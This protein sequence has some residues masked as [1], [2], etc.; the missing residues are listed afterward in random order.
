MDLRKLPSSIEVLSPAGTRSFLTYQPTLVAALDA[1]NIPLTSEDRLDFQADLPLAPGSRYVVTID[2]LHEVRLAWNGFVLATVASE[3]SVLALA[4]LAGYTDIPPE[5]RDRVVVSPTT[6]VSDR[7]EISYVVVGTRQVPIQEGIPF[8]T[9]YVEDPAQRVGWTQETVK[10]KDGIR[11]TTYEETYENGLLTQRLVV[12]TETLKN[13]VSRVVRVGTSGSVPLLA[14]SKWTGTVASRYRAIAP[15][16]IPNGSYNYKSFTDN[17]DGTITVDGRT[18]MAQSMAKRNV[19]AY[20]A[21]QWYAVTHGGIKAWPVGSDVPEGPTFTGLPARRGMVATYAFKENGVWVATRL[22]MGTVVFVE[23]YGLAV[24]ADIHHV[25]FDIDRIDC[26]YDPGEVLYNY[27]LGLTN[28]R[29]YI[30]AWP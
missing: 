23:R 9:T 21:A 26:A 3:D 16:L 6:A 18:F 17:G 7:I 13:P 10:G 30:L 11:Q 24:V 14:R 20:D 22:P 4:G 29:V 25:T 5:G 2:D 12:K 27:R 1:A 15:M 8:G 28:R 19:T